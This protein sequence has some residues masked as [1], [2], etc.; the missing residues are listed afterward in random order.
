MAT[1]FSGPGLYCEGFAK[2]V[3]GKPHWTGKVVLV[4]DALERPLHWRKPKKIFVNS[5]SDLF[6]EALPYDHI[7]YVFGIMALC[8]QHTFQVLTKR[9]VRMR[10]YSERVA[11]SRPGD[12]VHNAVFG[13]A[14]EL[15]GSIA[16]WPLPHV[17]FGVSVENDEMA[18]QRIPALQATPAAVRWVSYEPALGPVEWEQWLT[19]IDGVVCGG[20]SGPGARPM[21]LEWARAARD[22]CKKMGVA[23]HFKQWGAWVPDGQGGMKRV[24]KKA[25][26]RVL[27][28]RTH[29]EWPKARKTKK[30]KMKKD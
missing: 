1:R 18:A 21:K 6:H 11:A 24:G 15:H 19:G 12:E 25:A 10:D 9:A 16:T 5:M 26:G 4:E 22:A 27:D 14:N 13:R 23:F 29:D 28:G 30:P 20:E 3:H 17:H 8:P 7:D 2:L